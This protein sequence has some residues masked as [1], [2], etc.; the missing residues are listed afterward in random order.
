MAVERKGR[1][2]RTRFAFGSSDPVGFGSGDAELMAGC[3]HGGEESRAMMCE[4]E[5]PREGPAPPT[6]RGTLSESQRRQLLIRASTTAS[7]LRTR[8]QSSRSLP[9]RPRRPLDPR[10]PPHQLATTAWSEVGA[11]RHRDGGGGAGSGRSIVLAKA[12]LGRRV[13]AWASGM[14]GS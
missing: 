14:E 8:R 2:K 4:G 9:S 5:E 3:C 1:K 12:R 6:P 10:V 7:S 13:L 11:L